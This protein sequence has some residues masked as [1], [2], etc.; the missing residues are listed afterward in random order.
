VDRDAVLDRDRICYSWKAG[1]SVGAYVSLLIV[2]LLVY[3]GLRNSFRRI[4]LDGRIAFSTLLLAS[5]ASLG[6][7]VPNGSS[8]T[9]SLVWILIVFSGLFCSFYALYKATDYLFEAF[10]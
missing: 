7:S 2:A 9:T 5:I 8:I 10:V 4:P 6:I 3:H 1:K